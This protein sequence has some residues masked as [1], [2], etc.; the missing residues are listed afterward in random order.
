MQWKSAS[1][2]CLKSFLFLYLALLERHLSISYIQLPLTQI[3]HALACLHLVF[4]WN[5]LLDSELLYPFRLHITVLHWLNAAVSFEFAL[6]LDLYILLISVW[7][8]SDYSQGIPPPPL[9]QCYQTPLERCNSH[10][11]VH[12][13]PA[14]FPPSVVLQTESLVWLQ[15]RK[16][17]DY[18]ESILPFLSSFSM[19]QAFVMKV[20]C[21]PL[22]FRLFYFWNGLLH[23]FRLTFL[24]R[25]QQ[26]VKETLRCAPQRVDRLLD[27]WS[28]NV[29]EYLHNQTRYED[30][31][32][33]SQV[34]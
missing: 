22:S 32:D 28:W 16:K 24:R 1:I 33:E 13:Y 14:S 23:T 34:L 26:G 6:L 9:L 17:C 4:R 20:P 7:G 8:K 31:Y 18:L 29:S 21:I 15:E 27:H 19:S 5:R 10:C 2:S 11:I 30:I 3:H 12:L 25:V